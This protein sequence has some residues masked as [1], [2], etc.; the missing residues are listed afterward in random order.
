MARLAD[1]GTERHVAGGP[2]WRAY[3]GADWLA[4]PT[5]VDLAQGTDGAPHIRLTITRPAIPDRQPAPFGALDARLETGRDL[6]AARDALRATTPFATLARA[7]VEACHLALARAG[8]DAIFSTQSALYDATQTRI[9]QHLSHDDALLFETI[10]SHNESPLMLT[11]AAAVA[12]VAPRVG[13]TFS[14]DAEVHAALRARLRGGFNRSDINDAIATLAPT[15]GAAFRHAV[16]DR[17]ADLCCTTLIHGSDGHPILTFDAA[18][19]EPLTWDLSLPH[20]TTRWITLTGSTSQVLAAYLDRP[21]AAPLVTRTVTSTFPQG[22]RRVTAYA[23]L[24]LAAPDLHALGVTLLAPAAP[25]DRPAAAHAAGLF[26]AAADV[27]PLDLDL[28]L[29]E[30]LAYDLACFSVAGP[31]P[32]VRQITGSE[33]AETAQ[34]LVLTAEDFGLS[35][36]TLRADPTLLAQARF[37]AR[38]TYVCDGVDI[39]TVVAL[40]EVETVLTLPAGL[41]NGTL[42]VTATD[43]AGGVLHLPPGPLEST[44]LTLSRFA[45]Y[46]PQTVEIIAATPLDHV[47]GIDLLPPEASAEDMQSIALTPDTPRRSFTYFS[48]SIFGGGLRW[49]RTGTD[50]WT[51]HPDSTQ[52]IRVS[53]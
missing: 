28:A 4:A 40:T 5:R 51:P 53:I 20:V 41:S 47:V 52:P 26:G 42:T 45:S 29:G 6:E 21:D 22:R 10:L 27:L 34:I 30:P 1:F 24:P 7:Q 25:P 37:E 2:V 32:N 46:G 11:G 31:I 43:D 35:I 18:P 19:T 49:R 39:A 48:A 3:A 15:K 9:L 44:D 33:R 38:I 14:F 12:G 16:S 36:V 50:D 8:D 13:E 17:I 23:N